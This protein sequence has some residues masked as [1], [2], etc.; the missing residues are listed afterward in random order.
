MN[1]C[2]TYRMSKQ[3]AVDCIP[4]FPMFGRDPISFRVGRRNLKRRSW[5]STPRRRGREHSCVSGD[6]KWVM[7]LAMRNLAIAQQRDKE[8]Y[9]LVRR[10]GWDR[11]KVSFALGD[12][13]MI[14][15]VTKDTLD[16]PSR[17][18]V[19]RIVEIEPSGV[20]V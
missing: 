10:G 3:K 17:P 18:H 7:P 19:L 5:I 4:H 6:F 15:Q 11:P 8:R 20:V 14:R 12:F 2:H 13:V 9:R 1:C 16:V